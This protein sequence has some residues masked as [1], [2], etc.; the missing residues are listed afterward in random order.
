MI[1]ASPTVLRRTPNTADLFSF[2]LAYSAFVLYKV[3]LSCFFRECLH[4]IFYTI[5]V[6]IFYYYVKII[7]YSF[8]ALFF[9]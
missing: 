8:I 7:H 1:S 6:K 2:I 3:L 9:K 4:K 5:K